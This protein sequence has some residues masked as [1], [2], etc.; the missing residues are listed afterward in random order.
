MPAPYKTYR[1]P[2]KLSILI[3]VYNAEKHIGRCLDSLLDQNISHTDYEIIIRDDGSADQ[4]A[5]IIQEYC[6]TAPNVKLYSDT[7]KGAYVQRNLLLKQASGDYIYFMDADDYLVRK[8]LSTVLGI[9]ID[10][11]LDL[12]CFNIRIA[13]WEDTDNPTLNQDDF[14][15]AR[16]NVVSG[17]T[18]L[19]NH[20]EMRHEIWWYLIKKEFL[21]DS[22]IVFEE[23]RYHRDVLFTLNLFLKAQRLIFIPTI[24][25]YYFQSEGSIMRTASR[26]HSQ[27]LLEA[28]KKL[29]FDI[30]NL[31]VYVEK[32]YNRQILTRNLKYNRDKFAFYLI[33]RMIKAG[34][35]LKEIEDL[36]M[37]LKSLNS[38][39]IK[40]YKGKDMSFKKFNFLKLLIHNKLLLK[41]YLR[42][43]KKR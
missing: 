34:Y 25:Y 18:Y 28:G 5:A 29:V 36:Y 11:D 10:N 38:Y 2:M 7:N 9:A 37:Y 24:I 30:N 26:E 40:Y 20:Q 19:E 41:G 3:P 6:K 14:G 13:T 27:R 35:T 33:I 22:G 1:I 43:F 32:E 17:I 4:T 21:I 8:S 39:P 42:F 23:G 12:S 15:T 16:L 31:V